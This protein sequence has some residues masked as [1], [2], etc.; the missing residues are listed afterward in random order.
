VFFGLLKCSVVT[1]SVVLTN[2]VAGG[3]FTE[4]GGSGLVPTLNS[5]MS[6]ADRMAAVRQIARVGINAND[7]L[8]LM[9]GEA[10]YEATENSYWK[11]YEF[12][13]NTGTTRNFKNVEEYFDVELGIGK[14]K[15]YYL[16]Q[17]YKTFVVDLA[18][19]KDVLKDL[20]WSKV[21]ELT[22]VINSSNWQDLLAT[23]K[24]MTVKQVIDYVKS[25]KS[26]GTAP[27]TTAA[28]ADSTAPAPVEDDKV[29][30][31]TFSF[32]LHPAQAEN[33]KKALELAQK[34]TGSDSNNNLIDLI[35]TD[36]QAAA[37]GMTDE[38]GAMY[39]KLD[40]QIRNIERVYGVK[41][42]VKSVDTSV[43]PGLVG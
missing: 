23:I 27:A 12:V 42:E 21:K 41:L 3:I 43:A 35:C 39:E 2:F 17:I 5:S 31:I 15:G 6:V 13:D 37:V 30:T 32:R 33:L 14:R 11:S 20:E 16:I 22:K 8:D 34:M 19:P 40:F 10:L 1:K 26:G 28:P 29:K 4:A 7:K 9:V 38:S 36:F 24:D 18:L 25:L